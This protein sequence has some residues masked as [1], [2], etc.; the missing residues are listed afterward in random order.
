M[1]AAV[2]EL[3]T[4]LVLHHESASWVERALK[5]VYHRRNIQ[6]GRRKGVRNLFRAKM[7]E[8]VPDTFFISFALLIREPRSHNP[9]G[10]ALFSFE[11]S[12]IIR[13]KLH[14]QALVRLDRIVQLEC[15]E[16]FRVGQL[17]DH[18]R[19]NN[20]P[21]SDESVVFLADRSRVGIGT[22]RQ[23]AAEPR[24]LPGRERLVEIVPNSFWNIVALCG[25]S[26]FLSGGGV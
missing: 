18:E 10:P 21:E 13:F 8:N 26:T 20:W 6:Q 24:T 3:I 4:R 5:L 12:F 19:K 15:E 11:N 9:L 23:T 1:Y 14:E 25:Q 2:D 17:L 16:I 22:D 7:G